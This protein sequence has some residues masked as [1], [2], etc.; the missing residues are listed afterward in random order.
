MFGQ[1]E[2]WYLCI[3]ART[4]VEFQLVSILNQ[5]I[6]DQSRSIFDVLSEEIC[7]AQ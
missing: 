2:V 7:L 6:R 1:L 3:E 4:T 5:L